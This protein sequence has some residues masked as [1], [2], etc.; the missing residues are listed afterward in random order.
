MLA[1][2]D[3]MV[4][5]RVHRRL[6]VTARA[7]RTGLVTCRESLLM[8]PHPIWILS[9]GRWCRCFRRSA[10]SGRCS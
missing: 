8:L 3:V 4:G 2:E 5:E 10:F 1:A 7:V 6:P 9:P